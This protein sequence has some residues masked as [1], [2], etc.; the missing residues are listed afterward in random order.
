MSTI[1]YSSL[2]LGD[3]AVQVELLRPGVLSDPAS[4]AA[5]LSQL[6]SCL[7]VDWPNVQCIQTHGAFTVM[8]QTAPSNPLALLAKV[9]DALQMLLVQFQQEWPARR[10]ARLHQF[11][12]RY[13]GSHGQDLSALAAQL[14]MSEAKLI[15]THSGVEYTV[16][17]LGF[18]PGFA[19][20]A[21]LPTILHVPRLNTPRVN[22]PAGSLAIAGGYCAIYPWQSPGGWHLLGTVDVPLFNPAFADAPSLLQAGDRVRFVPEEPC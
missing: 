17:F 18:L 21:G 16:E 7:Q 11:K 15:G 22:V 20:L 19:Y 9:E 6:Q 13:G 1:Q 4:L 3:R 12:V 14:G 8:L 5:L 10:D 2:L